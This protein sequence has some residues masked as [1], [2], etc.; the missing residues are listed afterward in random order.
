[1]WFN[2]TVTNTIQDYEMSAD[3]I[4]CIVL[5][6]QVVYITELTIDTTYTFCLFE[7]TS[8]AVSPF[9]CVAYYLRPINDSD[10]SSVW[11]SKDDQIPVILT[12]V[13]AFAIF[14]WLGII[15]GMLLIRWYPNGLKGATNVK[16]VDSG[17]NLKVNGSLHS[18]SN[19]FSIEDSNSVAY[20]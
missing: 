3:D 10:S 12:G 15:L 4:S 14:V 19:E 1:M 9:D 11:I 5:L 8:T 2:D 7:N 13:E 20:R 16:I 6:Q 18:I 17:V